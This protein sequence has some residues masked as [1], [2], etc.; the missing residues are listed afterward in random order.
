MTKRIDIKTASQEAAKTIYQ[1][2]LDALSAA[3]MSYDPAIL[4]SHVGFPFR[5]STLERDFL[6]ESEEDWLR[7][8]RLFHQN[9]VSLGVNH[10]IRLVSDADFLSENYIEGRHVTHTLCNATPV[11][12]SYE[13]RTVL[14]RKDGVWRIIQMDSAMQND[15]WPIS[16]PKVDITH[17]PVW[18]KPEPGA[19]IRC[20]SASPIALY[21]TYLDALTRTVMEDDFNGWCEMC[22][23]PHTIHMEQIDEVIETSE[24][25][26]PFFNM[27]RAQITEH[28]VDTFTRK[29]DHAEFISASQ[30]C[31]YHTTN[32]TSKG[33]VKLGPVAGRYILNRTGTTWRMVSV[34]NSLANAKFPYSLPELSDA[35]VSMRDI[36]E[37]T[38]RQ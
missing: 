18:N 20:T 15:R 6:I 31:G 27:L 10:Y 8:A 1:D 4:V 16:M 21:Q 3:L 2:I 33:E 5:M 19:D 9:L 30:I 26:R 28:K 35:L 11:V 32:L 24:Q 37:R 36:Q 17:K 34:T 22:D 38:T 12:P 13:N 14:T 7:S 23:F 29:A 25:I